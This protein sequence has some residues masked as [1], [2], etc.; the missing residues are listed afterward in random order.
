MLRNNCNGVLSINT[1]RRGLDS[2]HALSIKSLEFIK[3]TLAI[4]GQVFLR[5]K[6]M[7][8]KLIVT[9]L[10]GL[11]V[12]SVSAYAGTL[13]DTIQTAEKNGVP[14]G[15]VSLVVNRAKAEGIPDAGI[16][17]MLRT[18]IHAKQD[19][20]SVPMITNK[21]VEGLSKHAQAERIVDAANRLEQSYKQAGMLYDQIKGQIQKGD[22]KTMELKESMSIA[23]FNGVKPDQLKDLYRAAP[24][25][26]ASYYI[27]GTVS[28]T[29]LISSG[30]STEQGISFMKKEFSS[31]KTADE[32][33]HK[34]MRLIEQP[35]GSRNDMME[36]EMGQG[37]TMQMN[38]TG[39][40]GNPSDRMPMN[41]DMNMHN[42]RN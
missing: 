38:R 20:V 10:M 26:G 40:P 4:D 39:I 24:G 21:I 28:L 22:N 2:D 27:M 5:G 6:N 3:S 32:I 12:F 42:Q 29:S 14:S 9:G 8:I 16:I 11:L 23:I 17:N 19:N 1:A 13:S 37:N 33:Q 36:R 31:H 25:S 7:K 15:Q 18:V 30:Y 41:Q 35:M 34:T